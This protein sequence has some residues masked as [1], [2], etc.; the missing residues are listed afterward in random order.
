MRFGL[1]SGSVT[2]GVLRGEKS[3]FQLFGDTVNTGK[4]PRCWFHFSRNTTVHSHKTMFVTSFIALSRVTPNP[5]QLQEWKV[6]DN[7]IRF[8]V[9]K[10]RQH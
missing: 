10:K 2:A 7:G 5:I 8:N 1:H 3:R 4:P 9:H 6:Q